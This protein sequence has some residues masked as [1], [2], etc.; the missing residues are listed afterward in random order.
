MEIL[1]Y[2]IVPEILNSVKLKF[3]LDK[4]I[5]LVNWKK[6]SK[7]IGNKAQSVGKERNRTEGIKHHC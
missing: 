7:N 5:P 4:K 3:I 1:V 2:N 6:V